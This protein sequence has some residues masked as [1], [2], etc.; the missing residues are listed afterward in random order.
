MKWVMIMVAAVALALLAAG[1]A[2]GSAATDAFAQCLTDKGVKMYGD[3]WCPHCINQKELFGSSFEKVQYVEC[4]LPNRGGQ[5]EVCND[6]GINGYP[7]WEFAD[8]S[9]VEGEMN[10]ENIAAK[11]GC[12]LGG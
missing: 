3:Y 2:K 12:P 4:S 7:T 9:R 8:G 5:N 1:C 10:M 11:A 6:A